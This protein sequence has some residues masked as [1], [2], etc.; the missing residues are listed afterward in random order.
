MKMLTYVGQ[1]VEKNLCTKMIIFCD[2]CGIRDLAHTAPAKFHRHK[3]GPEWALCDNRFRSREAALKEA[4]EVFERRLRLSRELPGLEACEIEMNEKAFAYVA[5]LYEKLKGCDGETPAPESTDN[6]RQVRLVTRRT[7]KKQSCDIAS[8]DLSSTAGAT[9]SFDLVTAARMSNVRR[10][11]EANME[12]IRKQN[13]GDEA[14]RSDGGARQ[15]SP[16][17]GGW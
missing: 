5:Q 3:C 4:Y 14:H 12:E 17:K 15:S 7:R 10:R 11:W 8:A 1:I 6:D 16:P 2:K 9:A 13:A